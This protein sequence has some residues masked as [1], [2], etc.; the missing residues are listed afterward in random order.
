MG[1]ERFIDFRE[2]MLPEEID[3]LNAYHAKVYETLE[4]HLNAEEQAWLREKTKPFTK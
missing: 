1:L 2:E 4:P 3:W